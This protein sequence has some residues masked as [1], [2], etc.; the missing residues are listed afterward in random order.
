MP[1]KKGTSAGSVSSNSNANKTTKASRL[2]KDRVYFGSKGKPSKAQLAL[3]ERY[4]ADTNKLL[5]E[6]TI[7]EIVSERI[8]D[9][10]EAVDNMIQYGDPKIFKVLPKV[11]DEKIK[12]YGLFA[13]EYFGKNVKELEGT[14]VFIAPVSFK[15]C[16]KCNKYKTNTAFYE[17]FSDLY[18][19]TMPICR[20]CAKKLFG[21]YYKTYRDLRECIILISQKFDIIVYEPALELVLKFAETEEGKSQ[22]ISGDILGKYLTDLWL[23]CHINNI[24][25]ER[26]VFAESNL[27]GI[28]FKC[29]K[30]RFTM[31]SIYNDR[32]QSDNI[33]NDSIVDDEDDKL[34]PLK[35]LR[36][37]WGPIYKDEELKFL[38]NIY[39]QYLERSVID[40]LVKER[41]L[42]QVCYEEL[43]LY[44]DRQ[45]QKP[46]DKRIAGLRALLKD[47]GISEKKSANNNGD[48]QFGSLGEFIR[49]AEQHEPIIV[50]NH[51][52]VDVDGIKKLWMSMVGA[53]IRTL[54]RNN[55]Y[56][57]KFEEN[58]K[59]YTADIFDTEMGDS[60]EQ[61]E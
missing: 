26:R 6:N 2:N 25:K 37:K 40:S 38:E 47:A 4:K 36:R 24:P 39:N 45:A 42:L 56:T 19:G 23:Q 30:N 27:G 54:G 31:P 58:Y 57:E 22:L 52:F 46:V 60:D 44:Q 21:K 32:L 33:E 35:K 3:I 13:Q 41:L 53:L 49:H 14:E 15:L 48:S 17:S 1:V 7:D 10:K 9:I 29:I 61:S 51:K 5:V 55:E 43:G 59:P 12:S 50:K 8:E 16:N 20:D 28:P 11:L 18:D 34:P